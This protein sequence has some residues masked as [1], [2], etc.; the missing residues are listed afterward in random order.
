MK[1]KTKIGIAI[2]I[3]TFVVLLLGFSTAKLSLYFCSKCETVVKKEQTPNSINCPT[4]GT[5]NWSKVGELGAI[6]YLCKKCST[7]V[8]LENTPATLNC[9]KGGTHKWN[10]L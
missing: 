4:G 5:H 9:S 3:I 1:S 7:L 2:F 6:P 8:Y 10:K